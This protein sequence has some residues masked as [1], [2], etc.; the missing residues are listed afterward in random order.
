MR[1]T[2]LTSVQIRSGDAAMWTVTESCTEQPYGHFGH[3]E[4]MTQLI[5]FH[6]VALT[7][8]DLDSSV[9]WYIS[10][11][12][13][14][15]VF[16]EDNENS[17]ACILRF[18]GGGFGIGLVE[19]TPPN[20][21]PFDPRRRGLDHVAFTVESLEEIEQWAVRLTEAGVTHS[22]VIPIPPGAILN[23]KDPAGV[24]LALFWDRV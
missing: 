6:H 1:V 19:H 5:G 9:D 16:R 8:N 2:S 7:T 20:P 18:P 3:A 13:F 14:E 22:G 12:G 10:V 4:A 24:A 23:F 17:R 11:L 21:D 15:E